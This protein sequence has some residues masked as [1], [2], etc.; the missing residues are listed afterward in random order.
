MDEARRVEV[1]QC[2]RL[3]V[4]DDNMLET[5]TVFAVGEEVAWCKN[6]ADETCVAGIERLLTRGEL[7]SDG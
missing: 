4:F 2:W 5:L 3:Y 1:G 6:D 7:I